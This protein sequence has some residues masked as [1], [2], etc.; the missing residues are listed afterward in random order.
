MV[1]LD[2]LLEVRHQLVVRLAADVDA[3]WQCTTFISDLLVGGLNY[4]PE[5]AAAGT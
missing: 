5:T 2:V 3:T 4:Y 1:A